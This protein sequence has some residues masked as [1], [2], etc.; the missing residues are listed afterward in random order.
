MSA[1]RAM[2]APPHLPSFSD[3]RHLSGLGLPVLRLHVH[4]FFRL[5]LDDWYRWILLVLRVQPEGERAA[6]FS[7]VLEACI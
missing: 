7:L 4:H 5:L 6:V 3:R 1:A 2:S